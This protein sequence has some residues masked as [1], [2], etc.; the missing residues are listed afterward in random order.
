MRS[1]L[2]SATAMIALAVVLLAACSPRGASAPASN[3]STSNTNATNVSATNPAASQQ[4]AASNDDVARIKQ[5]ELTAA[6][7]KGAVVLF[8]VRDKAS[9]EAGHI[10]GAKNVPW[11]E[12]EHRLSEFPK[13]KRIVTYCA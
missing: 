13:D 10:K 6:L 9:Y 5:D 4:E 8:D 2:I 12:V 3:S 11:S 1:I 7:K